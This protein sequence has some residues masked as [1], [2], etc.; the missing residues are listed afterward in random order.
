M[1]GRRAC[2]PTKLSQGAVEARRWGRGGERARCLG[3]QQGHRV[4]P[5]RCVGIVVIELHPHP[6]GARGAPHKC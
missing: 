1:G 2:V 4:L 3:N 5:R 6:A